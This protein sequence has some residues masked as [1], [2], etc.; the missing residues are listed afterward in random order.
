MLIFYLLVLFLSVTGPHAVSS[1]IRKCHF[2]FH[3]ILTLGR[4]KPVQAGLVTTSN[5][6]TGLV[7]QG[8]EGCVHEHSYFIADVRSNSFERK[9]R[10]F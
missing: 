8:G 4:F 1:I 10:D 6:I 7:I 9:E 5:S 3:I 2:S